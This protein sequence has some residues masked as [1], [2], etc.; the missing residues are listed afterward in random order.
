METGSVS[1]A[2]PP[3]QPRRQDRAAGWLALRRAVSGSQQQV[4]GPG[5]GAPRTGGGARSIKGGA[6]G[7]GGHSKPVGPALPLC[8]PGHT[9]RLPP[10]SY[11]P[12]GPGSLCSRRRQWPDTCGA[13]EL[14]EC[15]QEARSEGGRRDPLGPEPAELGE[16]AGLPASP[17]SRSG[18]PCAV[19]Q[20]EPHSSPCT[21][22]LEPVSLSGR[23]VQG[24]LRTVFPGFGAPLPLLP[25]PASRAEATPPQ[26]ARPGP[27]PRRP[28]TRHP[29]SARPHPGSS[30]FPRRAPRS[31]A[32]SPSVALWRFG[33]PPSGRPGSSLG[34]VHRPAPNQGVLFALFLRCGLLSEQGGGGEPSPEPAQSR[35]TLLSQGPGLSSPELKLETCRRALALDPSWGGSRSP[36]PALRHQGLPHSR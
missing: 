18:V 23:A 15:R 17:Q 36:T 22:A 28:V 35:Q 14:P 25:Y 10:A 32:A 34:T 11:S 33:A 19:H 27:S 30:L 29:G 9:V 26:V 20:P 12:R 2:P 8:G 21:S 31:G 3:R 6:A 13:A 24:T 16:L 4:N 1:A 7:R 5:R